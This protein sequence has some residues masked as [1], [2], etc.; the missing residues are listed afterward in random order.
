MSRPSVDVVVPFAGS[1]AALTDLCARVTRLELCDGDS[2]TVVDNRSHTAEPRHMTDPHLLRAPERQ[3]S[4]FA[5]NRGA[6]RGSGEWLLFIDADVDPPA[7][8]LDRY[9]DERPAESTGVLA[10]AVEDE[11]LSPGER[12]SIAARY[13]R[14]RRPMSQ[15]STLRPGKWAY[16]Q[17]ANCAVRRSAFESVGGFCDD[18]R[19]G[20]DADLCF[21]LKAAGWGI[22]PR[23]AASVVHYSRRSLTAMLRQRARHGSGTAWL[24]RRY[25]GAFPRTGLLWLTAWTA[26]RMTRGVVSTAQR[27]G[28]EALLAL[29]EPISLWAFELGRLF[30]NTVRAAS[31]QARR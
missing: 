25:P 29:V 15:R 24:N 7:D 19:S 23:D 26:R 28:D 12:H 18:I 17:T 21:R 16:A 10:G 22:E 4:Y 20:G 3:S 9:F 31:P 30:P 2:L 11:P 1:H 27:R 5:R 13:A 8:L 14:L 6:S